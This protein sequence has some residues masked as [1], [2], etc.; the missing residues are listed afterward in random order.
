MTVAPPSAPTG[1]RSSV[2]AAPAPA[3]GRVTVPSCDDGFAWA[4]PLPPSLLHRCCESQR[5]GPLTYFASQKLRQGP[6]RLMPPA[7]M[8]P[9]PYSGEITSS[10]VTANLTRDV[11][12]DRVQST[13]HDRGSGLEL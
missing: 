2:S 10:T 6:A 11:S 1:S 13:S 9:V 5:D 3:R 12:A 7:P 8:L 4:S